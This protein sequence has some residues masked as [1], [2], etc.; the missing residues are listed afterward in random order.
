[1]YSRFFW[2]THRLCII[3]EQTYGMYTFLYVRVLIFD[4]PVECIIRTVTPTR[5]ENTI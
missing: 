4:R 2:Y 3:I 1:M 5:V